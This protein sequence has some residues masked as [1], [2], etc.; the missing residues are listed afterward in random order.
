MPADDR[1]RSLHD[2]FLTTPWSVVLG[3]GKD[4]SDEALAQLFR[5]YWYPLCAFVRRRWR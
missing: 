3:A 4:E 1:P 2:A 5:D